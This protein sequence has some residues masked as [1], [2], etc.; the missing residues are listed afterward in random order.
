MRAP[1]AKSEIALISFC[2]TTVSKRIAALLANRRDDC[3]VAVF[4][5]DT[6][7]VC[8]PVEIFRSSK[9]FRRPDGCVSTRLEVIPT[10]HGVSITSA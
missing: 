2:G 9:K 8:A 5:N 1:F 7:I 4:P 6:K 10:V 3:S